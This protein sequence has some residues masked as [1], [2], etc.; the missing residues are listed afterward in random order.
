MARAISGADTRP[1]P[2]GWPALRKVI[3]V[4]PS[5]ASSQV[6]VVCIG[7][8]PSAVVITSSSPSTS[9]VIRYV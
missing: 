7:N 8:G 2:L 4:P 3:S 9:S 6:Y 1:K 5:S